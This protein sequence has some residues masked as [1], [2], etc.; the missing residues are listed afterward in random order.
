MIGTT[1][2]AF[3]SKPDFVKP[4]QQEVQY[5]LQTLSHYFPHIRNI[6]YKAFAGLRVLPKTSDNPFSR[7]RETIL[8]PDRKR[9][10]RIMTIYGGKLTEYRMVSERLMKAIKPL[11]PLARKKAN[12]REIKLDNPEG[13]L[14]V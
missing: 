4:L 13:N 8:Y 14:K 9:H 6:K 12:T 3:H 7:S 10:P 2:T 5:L 1:E 11:L